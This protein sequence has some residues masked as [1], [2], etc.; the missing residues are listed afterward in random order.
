MRFLTTLLLL[1]SSLPLCSQTAPAVRRITEVQG[2]SLTSDSIVSSED[3]QDIVRK[4]Q[5]NRYGPNMEKYVADVARSVVGDQGY[6]KADV[7]V[8]KTEV[9]NETTRTRNV[10]VTLRIR[11]GQQY[12]VARIKFTGDKTFSAAQ[13][14]Q[15]VPIADGDVMSDKKM[16]EGME[17][18]RTL[19]ASKGY[20]ELTAVPE[21]MADDARRTVSI[22]MDMG[23]GPQFT[24]LGITLDGDR[25]WPPDKAEKLQ[26]IAGRYQ[27]SHSVRVF[28]DAVKQ[29]F[30][31]IFPGCDA[32]QF[33]GTTQG[34]EIPHLTANVRW[35]ED[36]QRN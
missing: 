27:G 7:E 34:G 16:R 33:V 28:I 36:C 15:A 14:H 5:Q 21:V 11:E 6:L 20:M 30:T 35:P 24:V 23:K 19:Y 31:E 8:V 10:A 2:V 13:L 25:E 4:I 22:T 12:R 3:F 26:A 1:L 32:N 29:T 17:N 18:M 9:R